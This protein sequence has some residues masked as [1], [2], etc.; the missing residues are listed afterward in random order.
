[1]SELYGTH[2]IYMTLTRFLP[3]TIFCGL[4]SQ[5]L[6]EYKHSFIFKMLFNSGFLANN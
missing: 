5:K 6:D 4:T 2:I 3:L 1:M